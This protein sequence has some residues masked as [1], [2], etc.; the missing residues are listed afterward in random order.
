MDIIE[1]VYCVSNKI[2]IRMYDNIFYWSYTS[3]NTIVTLMSLG[4]TWA[5][6]EI[7]VFIIVILLV[8]DRV[9]GCTIANWLYSYQNTVMVTA[10]NV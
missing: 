1:D 10:I 3:N 2:K 8:Y 5:V 9:F 4:H 7:C 6:I